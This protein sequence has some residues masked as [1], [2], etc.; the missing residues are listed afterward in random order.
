MEASKEGVLFA[1]TTGVMEKIIKSIKEDKTMNEL[2]D[3]NTL[4]NTALVVTKDTFGIFALSTAKLNTEQQKEFETA[5]KLI[6][7]RNIP[8]PEK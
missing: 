5:A 8:M 2:F 4:D 6:L 7:S 1:V 3:G